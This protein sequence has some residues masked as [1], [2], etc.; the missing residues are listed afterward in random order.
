MCQGSESSSGGRP[1]N[2]VL[3]TLPVPDK[4]EDTCSRAQAALSVRLKLESFGQVANCQRSAENPRKIQVTYCDV[5]AAQKA[6]E[7]FGDACSFLPQVGRRSVRMTRAALD[8][9]PSSQVSKLE[10]KEGDIY[11]VEFYD[12]RVANHVALFAPI[13]ALTMRPVLEYEAVPACS[14]A[15]EDV[16]QED[17]LEAS[18]SEGEAATPPEQPPKRTHSGLSH[19]SL[20]ASQLS[21]ICW[22]DI[23]SKREQRTT[24]QIQLLPRRLCHPGA[25]ETLLN[26]LGLRDRVEWMEAKPLKASCPKS[27]GSALLKA[28]SVDDVPKLVKALHGRSFFGGIPIAVRFASVAPPPGLPAPMEFA[29]LQKSQKQQEP[30]S[31]ASTTPCSVRSPRSDK[32]QSF[33]RSTSSSVGSSASTTSAAG[34]LDL[35]LQCG[36]G[37]ALSPPP[38]IALAA[39]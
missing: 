17:S 37:R 35:N 3:I 23:A 7:V 13:A 27:L 19:Q 22:K 15:E 10:E 16:A 32:G 18:S 34:D 39:C 38:G 6:K 8:Y 36:R 26:K 5:R 20:M 28:K 2:Q 14:T 30:D 9:A 31:S 33:Q 11:Q 12:T 24:L 1:T 25:L 29:S 21:Q 4:N